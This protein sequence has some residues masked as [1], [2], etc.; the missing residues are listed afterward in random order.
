M[1]SDHQR[2]GCSLLKV[3]PANGVTFR[4]P[5]R[6]YFQMLNKYNQT[7][8]QCRQQMFSFA[9]Y[10]LRSREDAEDVLQEVLIQLWQHWSHIDPDKIGAWLMRATRNAVV[11]KVRSR[12][13]AREDMRVALEDVELAQES[14][15]E[16]EGFDIALQQAIR[17]LPEPSRSIII[18][19]DIQGMSYIEVGEVLDLNQSQVKVYLHRARRR[20]REM[21]SLRTLAQAAGI[22]GADVNEN[23]KRP[24]RCRQREY[25]DGK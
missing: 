11:D 16:G 20:L 8:E 7:V 3:S 15:E 12:K 14:D 22:I 21:S 9:C 17:E 25:H 2:Q 19:R 24:E 5:A 6:Q 1:R 4:A 23:V 18:M 13:S 10:S